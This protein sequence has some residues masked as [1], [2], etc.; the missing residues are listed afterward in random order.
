MII[1]PFRGEY[2]YLSNFYICPIK[3]NGVVYPS[4]E[5]AFQAA[6][7]TDSKI[8][9]K[10]CL[11][12]TPGRAKRLGNAIILRPG[13]E[14]MKVSTMR[15]LVKQKFNSDP[16][17]AK[18]LKATMGKILIEKNWWHD[19]F[20]GWCTCFDCMAQKHRNFLGKILMSVR[21]LL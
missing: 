17:L 21:D 6:K 13:W 9:Q 3:L 2:F 12:T 19:N 16:H 18:Q 15:G 14:E 11:A 7:T 10:I 8:R 5:H 4:V 1:G 20:W